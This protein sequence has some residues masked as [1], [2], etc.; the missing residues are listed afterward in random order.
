MQRLFP[1]MGEHLSDDRLVDLFSRELPLVQR[2]IARRHLAMCEVCQARQIELEGWRSDRVIADFQASRSRRALTLPPE[3]GAEFK[4]WLKTTVQQTAAQQRP[5]RRTRLSLP[6]A[7]ILIS[8]LFAMNTILISGAVLTAAGLVLLFTS[9]WQQRVP[10]ISS[11]DLLTR[12]E[13]WDR[14]QSSVPTGVI[15]QRVLITTHT[16][17]VERAIYRDVQRVRRPRRVTLAGPEEQIKNNLDKAGV[18]WDAPLSASR[19]QAWHDHLRNREDQVAWAGAH[20][21]RL[22]TVAAGGPVS[23]QSLTVRDTDFHPVQRRVVFR[24]RETIEIAELDFKVSPWGPENENFFEPLGGMNTAGSSPRV[25]MF[26]RVPEK[27]TESQLDETELSARLILN[28]LRADTGEQVTIARTAQDVEVNGLVET[29]DRKRALQSQLATV[30]HL[31]VSIRS[32]QEEQSLPGSD[33]G[34]KSVQVTSMPE[35]ESPFESYLLAHGRSVREISA[36]QQQLFKAALTVSQESN[37]IADLRRRF[38]GGGQTSVLASAT[39]AELLYN[40]HE[41]LDDALRKERDL[42]AEAQAVGSNSERASQ[43][44]SLLDGANENLAL[45]KE[46]TQ[47][48]GPA[49]RSAEAILADMSVRLNGLTDAARKAYERP[50]DNSAQSGKK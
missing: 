25:L 15:R 13:Q 30:S 16:H 12:A 4:Q 20:L 47:T 29:A 3:H 50:L 14:P 41:R 48:S 27:V 34:I 33:S 36:L 5:P 46:L 38:V 2:W 32:V 17:S 44:A 28:N 10:K 1:G 23:E 45:C 21:L 8:R 42:L 22:T 9:W 6:P 49:T 39:A 43:P 31:K 7:N 35:L 26:P 24:D 18:D 37:A 40:H 11:N 19:Y